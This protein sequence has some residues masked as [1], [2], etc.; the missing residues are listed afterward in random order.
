MP[1]SDATMLL[2]AAT[3]L[4]LAA[5]A[6]P[7]P[8]APECEVTAV[9]I[10]PQN[11]SVIV[12]KTLALSASV[13][14]QHCDPAPTVAWSSSAEGV[15]TVSQNG[16]LTGVTPGTALIT[17]AVAG[18]TATTTVTV[19]EVPVATV[20][21]LTDHSSRAAGQTTTVR[22]ELRDPDNQVLTGRAVRWSVSDMSRAILPPG[23]EWTLCATE[24]S[25]C[26][27]TGT[28]QVRYGASDTWSYRELTGG[29]P[30]TNAVFGD[31][32]VGVVKQCHIADLATSV[33]GGPGLQVTTIAS[34]IVA[35]TATPIDPP[36]SVTGNALLTITPAVIDHIAA[37][38]LI[39]CARFTD[40]RSYCWGYDQGVLGS[41][42]IASMLRR[43]IAA[44]G[45]V[46]PDL[47]VPTPVQG[48]VRFTELTAGGAHICGRT[49]AN[50]AYCWFGND[51]GQ[52]GDN[53]TEF[54]AQPVPVSGGH[55]FAGITAG[56]AF[57]CA[58]T[59]A[60]A[61][62]CWGWNG[63]G[64][65]GDGTTS[66]R[67]APH[68]V[69]GGLTFTHIAGGGAHTCGV[70][71]AGTYCWGHNQFGELGDNTVTHRL[72]PALVAGAAVFVETSPGFHHSCG[73]TVAGVAYCWGRNEF[74]E[75]G[76]NSTAQ[77]NAPVPVTGGLSFAQLGA[78]N[79]FTCGRST[80][81]AAYCWGA[82]F[83][84]RLG[85]NST[86]DRSA[87]TPVSGGLSFVQLVVGYSHACGL[88]SD[89]AMYCW[90][91]NAN[92]QIGDGTTVDRLV[93]TLVSIP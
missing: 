57:T 36:A 26:T 75:L 2:T 85:N 80:S 92:G 7:E 70:T 76:D 84:G 28:K 15:A 31:P 91:E 12:A 88:T 13:S 71:A 4:S 11:P 54:R 58:R 10:T 32:L 82:G 25:T 21:V 62:Y 24:G 81:G 73:R 29:T 19:L 69:S 66:N 23:S 38:G 65:L 56:F 18:V 46:S 33:S 67:L 1:S 72:V 39:T 86:A 3:I 55:A 79:A 83:N 89:G 49:A 14:Q 42:G 78:G 61:G 48:G 20:I 52:I 74:G 77:R 93:P 17:A 51:G 40:G 43:P 5:C 68:P 27:F 60:G 59:T 44:S 47:L 34:G 45:E 87:P 90:G 9:S 30:C 6:S 53:T 41:A 16:L 35:L 50:A 63:N 22:A 8:A 37:G 64:E